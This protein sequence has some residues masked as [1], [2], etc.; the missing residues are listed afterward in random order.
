VK[1]QTA[2]DLIFFDVTENV[3]T[4]AGLPVRLAV[5][6][7][8]L[9]VIALWFYSTLW[10]TA[11]IMAHDSKDYL[12]AGQD[13]ADFHLDQLQLRAP[14]YPLLLLLTGSTESPTRMLFFVSL[15]FHFVSIWLLATL[16]HRAGLQQLSLILFGLILLLPPYV[17]PAAYVL[18]ENLTEAMLVVGFVSFALWLLHKRRIWIFVSALTVGYAVLTRQT[19][20]FLA[21]AMAGYLL[22]FGLLFHWK[23]LKWKDRL[24][25]SLILL[26]GSVVLAGGYSYAN[27]RTFGYFG[28][29][30][31][32]LGQHLT[33][34]TF[35]VLELLPDEYAAV[36]ETLIK[37]RNFQ[38][39]T[40]PH[41]MGWDYI[42]AT[43]PELTRVT[44]L[45][46]A[47]LSDYLLR[48]NLLLIQKAPLA[49][50]EEVIWAFGSYWL[51]SSDAF[52]NMNSRYVQFLWAIIHFLL[53]G[54]FF[55]NMVLLFGAAI[56]IKMCMW[57]SPT[58]IPQPAREMSA[59]QLQ[60]FLYGL[61]GVVVI[62]TAAITC[63]VQ[64]GIARYRVPTDPLIVFMLFLGSHLWWRLVNLSR[65]TLSS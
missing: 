60:G 5:F 46:R 7:A 9:F 1:I 43:L 22:T 25:G 20:Q 13:L 45:Q 10:P 40:A 12:T 42:L 52:A 11:P 44:G 59:I 61:A 35:R 31:P 21:L 3:P 65:N 63:L 64:V 58:R 6:Y 28:L 62:Y 14:G 39:V 54:G 27:Y 34:K 37:G 55:L 56:Y 51:P 29:T 2:R 50:L 24:I 30:R 47:E 17:E 26:C 32:L 49:Y 23:L 16:L 15:A 53:I 36:R 57:I 33:Q 18:T 48:I 4:V 41:H 19:Y 38:V 8:T